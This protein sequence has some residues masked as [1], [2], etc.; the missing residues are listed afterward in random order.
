MIADGTPRRTGTAGAISVAI[1][2]ISADH[3]APRGTRV[4]RVGG[5]AR[6]EGMAR[7]RG[8][9]I[10]IGIAIEASTAVHASL[11]P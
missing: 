7:M 3:T 6:G 4:D 1:L 10:T 2:Q 5:A 8:T 11:A 9:G